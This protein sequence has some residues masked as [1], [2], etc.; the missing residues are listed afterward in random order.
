MLQHSTLIEKTLANMGIASLNEMQQASLEANQKNSDVIL[1][2]PTGSG[3]TLAFLLP[4]LLKLKPDTD[5]VQALVLAPSRELAQQIEQVFRS[6]GTGFKVNC[7]FGG[8][9]MN[10]EKRMLETPPAL[11]IATPGRLIDHIDRGHVDLSKVHTLVLDEF[12]KSLEFGFQAQME[13]VI[14]SLKTIEKRMLT[15]ATDTEEIPEFTGL[16]RPMKLN[17]LVEN[18]ELEGL[19][20]KTLRSESADK[21]QTLY[22]LICHLGNASTLVFCNQREFVENVS[23][24]LR[25]QRVEVGFFHGGLEQPERER[26]LSKFRNG[27]CSVFISTDL[28][29][30]G[31]DI[32]AVKNVVHFQL[33]VNEDSFI[34]RNGRTARMGATGT[35]ILLLNQNE[36]LPEYIQPVP[37]NMT[38]PAKVGQ[39]AKPEWATLYIGK[40]KKDKL[41]KMDIVGFLFK[42]GEL[43]KDELG[44]VEVKEFYSFAAVKRDKVKT[45]LQLVRNEKIKNMKTKI[46]LAE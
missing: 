26:A 20:V 1:L 39:P 7:C 15:S 46:E 27:S 33:P 13:A 14:S 22:Q 8:R 28:A 3:K 45:L 6:M 5:T 41:S 17:Y 42:K 11:L 40:G 31:L 21:M 37:V 29:A 12:D 2:S 4:L 23:D 43:Q 38:L 32:P 44:M 35:S 9:P 19:T 36:Y 30:R 18:N 34:H 10:N 24:Y 16:N 25:E